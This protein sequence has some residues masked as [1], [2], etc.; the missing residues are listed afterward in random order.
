MFLRGLLK[1]LNEES[2]N[3]R[4]KTIIFWDGAK[5]HKSKATL[6]LVEELKLPMLFLGPHSYDASPCELWFSLFKRVNINP[7]KIKAGKR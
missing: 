4:D 6:Q 5:Y 2:R 3:W 1:K 7:R